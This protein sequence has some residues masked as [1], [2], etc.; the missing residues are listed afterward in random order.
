MRTAALPTVILILVAALIVTA[1]YAW[2]LQNQLEDYEVTLRTA[3]PLLKVTP[4]AVVALPPYDD[5]HRWRVCVLDRT[6]KEDDNIAEK[7]KQAVAKAQEA[8]RTMPKPP[9]WDDPVPTSPGVLPRLR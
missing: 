2:R 9:G 6:L 4:G 3:G 1:G 5:P 8:T 7:I